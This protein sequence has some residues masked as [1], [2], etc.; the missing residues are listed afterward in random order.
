MEALLG[1]FRLQ[2]LWALR[3]FAYF[4][5]LF[6]V[7]ILSFLLSVFAFIPLLV[8]SLFGDNWSWQ[9]VW[10]LPL[11]LG[12]AQ[13]V[14]SVVLELVYG[15]TFG[16]QILGLMVLSG[17][18]GKPSL[19]G[20]V[21]RNLSKS[22]MKTESSV[23]S[24]NLFGSGVISGILSSGGSFDNASISCTTLAR[25]PPSDECSRCPIVIGCF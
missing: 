5:D 16:K 19:Y 23:S 2:S 12:L 15:A 6:F 9:G 4:L 25:D 22:S 3:L 17:K 20:V 13:I 24:A 18:G 21:L 11:Y 10:A 1:D 14:Y 7:G 8:G